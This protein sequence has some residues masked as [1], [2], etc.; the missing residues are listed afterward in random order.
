MAPVFLVGKS[1]FVYSVH[2][3]GIDSFFTSAGESRS[4]FGELITWYAAS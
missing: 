2:D 3:E 4:P 1:W